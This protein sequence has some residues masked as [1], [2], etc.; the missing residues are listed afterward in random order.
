MDTGLINVKDLYK[1]GEDFI[2][3]KQYTVLS[4]R[5]NVEYEIDLET[6]NSL[7]KRIVDIK[8]VSSSESDKVEILKTFNNA[9]S[10]SF[11]Y[12]PSNVGFLNKM[13]IITNSLLTTSSAGTQQAYTKY[14]TSSSAIPL[15]NNRV[16]KEA[17]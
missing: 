3:V 2:K 16:T 17:V 11:Y 6:E 14:E 8:T 15:I 4:A 9:N 12:N 1:N 13:E 10:S 7:G 5:A